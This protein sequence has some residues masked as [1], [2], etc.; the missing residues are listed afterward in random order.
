MAGD[1]E[2]RTLTHMNVL[3]QNAAHMGRWRWLVWMS[4]VLACWVIM[5]TVWVQAPR[6][7]EIDLADRNRIAGAYPP[8]EAGSWLRGDTVMMLPQT[9]FASMQVLEMRWRRHTFADAFSVTVTQQTATGM[10]QII[11]QLEPTMEWRTMR[12]LIQAP[13]YGGNTMRLVSS[14]QQFSG[15]RREIGALIQGVSVQALQVTNS[16]LLMYVSGFWMVCLALALW[17][18]H[19]RWLGMAV[20]SLLMIF[21]VVVLLQELQTGFYQPFILFTPIGRIWLSVIFVVLVLMRSYWSTT[22]KQAQMEQGRRFGLDLIRF[23]AVLCVVVAHAVPLFPEIWRRDKE[24]FQWFVY[25]GSMGVDMFFSLSGY[26]IGRIILRLLDNI[27][28]FEVVKRFWARRWLRTLPAAYVSAL[29]IWLFAPPVSFWA[30]LQSILFLGTIDPHYLVGDMSFWWSLGAE[31]VFYFLFPL[32]VYWIC[33]RFSYTPITSFIIAV[34]MFLVIPTIIR[35][36]LQQILD[37]QAGGDLNFTIYARLDSMVYGLMVAWLYVRRHVWFERVASWGFTPGLGMMLLGYLLLVNL[38]RWYMFGIFMAHTFM[39]LGSAL[40]IPAVERLRTMG[41][42]P[43]D[44][45]VSWGALISYSIYLYHTIIVSFLKRTTGDSYNATDLVWRFGIYL[46]ITGFV[47]WLSFRYV[48][49]PIL[50]WRDRRYP[51]IG[52]N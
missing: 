13:M 6:M 45:F 29:A 41:W 3:T 20:W 5:Y 10:P 23:L 50:R 24:V 28:Q 14:V 32:L 12:Y 2:G 16:T 42:R 9:Y 49:E 11:S 31:E 21:Y 17:M 39:T 46:C 43:L 4:L 7:Y 25:L 15:D 8:E 22:D 27:H 34:S 1:V 40:L 48:E 52:R 19:G 30:Y 51:E 47:S 35:F 33:R 18:S 36:V 38:N 37:L 44:R 26:L